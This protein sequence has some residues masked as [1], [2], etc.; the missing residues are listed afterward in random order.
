M[1]CRRPIVVIA[2][3]EGRRV[4]LFQDALAQR[5]LPGALVL[6][7]FDLL[8]G[9]RSFEDI[10]R[11]AIVRIDSP[12]KNFTVEKLL[13]L[14]GEP[15]A[16]AENGPVLSARGVR[17]LPEDAGRILYP[18]QWFHGFC[19]FLQ[20]LS[21]YLESRGD[22]RLISCPA[23]IEEMFDKV[24]C[25][26]HCK[27]AGVPVPVALP[28]V[29]TFD[30]LIVNMNDAG[31]QRIFVKLAHTSSA[32]GVVAVYRRLDHIEAI[33]SAEIVRHQGETWLYN[34]RTIHRY[35][36]LDDVRALIDALAPH[37]VH[38][39]EWLPKAALDGRVF[40][41]R[42]VMIGGEPMHSVARTSRSPITNLQLGSRRVDARELF[43]T[44][45]DDV[46]RQLHNSC[47]KTAQLFPRS[48]QMGLDVVFTPGMRR[49][50][51]LE[52]NAFGDLLPG[53]LFD[54]MSTYEAQVVVIKNCGDGVPYFGDLPSRGTD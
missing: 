15:Y 4:S 21:R 23:D 54:G 36:E 41:L 1:I 18:R 8:R 11:N 43:A 42:I 34:S 12:G 20:S 7:Y 14:A 48:L 28:P 46:W 32:S 6:S 47:R 3:P 16:A 44:A 22:L 35:T 30:E 26:E 9:V 19:H 50:A 2:N 38:V 53:V 13:L 29:S 49:H 27:S 24:N 31:L 25:H 17:S 45:S 51:V 5:E 52:I 37:R 33:T 40:D 10:P 39:E